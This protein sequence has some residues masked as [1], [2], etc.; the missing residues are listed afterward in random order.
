MLEL[1]LN[2]LEV[3]DKLNL[4]QRKVSFEIL[5]LLN[6]RSEFDL[7]TVTSKWFKKIDTPNNEISYE[8]KD[9]FLLKN[10]V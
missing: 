7:G 3:I 5:K 8:F 9:E 10:K 6:E 1:G 2:I 4:E